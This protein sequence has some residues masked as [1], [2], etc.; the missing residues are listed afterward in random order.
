MS[1][2]TWHGDA[3]SMYYLVHSR[4]F[5][6][7]WVIIWL[8]QTPFGAQSR[9]HSEAW[10]PHMR[11]RGWLSR[12]MLVPLFG[13]QSFLH[14]EAWRPRMCRCG[15]STRNTECITFLHNEAWLAHMRPSHTLGYHTFL[16]IWDT[17]IQEN[18]HLNLIFD[19]I[20]FMSHYISPTCVWTQSSVHI[21][22]FGIFFSSCL[23]LPVLKWGL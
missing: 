18:L 3:V 14:R 4:F 12:G 5:S 8:F 20:L 23:L 13:T 1:R 9:L 21:S 10:L 22:N 6:E 2:Q 19:D 11:S 16:F 15:Q 7:H 17:W